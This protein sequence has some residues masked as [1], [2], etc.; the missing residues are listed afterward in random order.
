VAVEGTEVGPACPRAEG[1]ITE[2]IE[3]GDVDG[4]GATQEDTEV[5]ERERRRWT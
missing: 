4:T 3:E 5:V 1:I 2:D